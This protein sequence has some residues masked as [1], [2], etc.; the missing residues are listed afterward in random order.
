MTCGSTARDGRDLAPREREA[1]AVG[2]VDQQHAVG[3]EEPPGGG[4]ELDRREVRGSLRAGVD[5][6]DEQ[7]GGAD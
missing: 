2:D 3:C 5:V 4:V 1:G 6:G 7:V